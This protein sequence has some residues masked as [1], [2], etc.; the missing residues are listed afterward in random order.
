MRFFIVFDLDGTLLNTLPDIAGAMNRVLLRN[1]LPGHPEESYKAFTGNGAKML[2][3]R[4]LGG[5]EDLLYKVYPEYLSE[6]A[7]HSREMTR[8]YEGV[9]QM[10]T[11]LQARGIQLIIYSNK[12]DSDTKSVVSHYFPDILFARVVGSLPGMPLKPDPTALNQMM[13]DLNLTPENGAYLGDT[14]TDMQCAKAAGIYSV[15]ALW[16]FQSEEVLREVKPEKL[17]SKPLDLLEIARERFL[18]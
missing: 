18:G 15:A 13:N 12:D 11:A 14:V 4:A 7:P 9:P 16:G 6:Y 10:L 5:R 8:P 3:L 1:G 2:T 17:I